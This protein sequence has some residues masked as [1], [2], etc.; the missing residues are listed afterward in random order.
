M[1]TQWDSISIHQIGENYQVLARLGSNSS[2]PCLLV[3]ALLACSHF[4]SS[5]A[6]SSQVEDTSICLYVQT[7]GSSVC[8]GPKLEITQMAMA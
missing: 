6:C 5:L 2:T 8:N 3:R 4:G 1:Y 7:H